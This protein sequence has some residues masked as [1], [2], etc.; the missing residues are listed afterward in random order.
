MIWFVRVQ[1][2]AVLLGGAT[3]INRDEECSR[4]CVQ[5]P[6]HCIYCCISY[7]SRYEIFAEIIVTPKSL[8]SAFFI[9]NFIVLR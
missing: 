2:R 1:A 9:R 8:R 4:Q 6:R 3:K 7:I 5:L